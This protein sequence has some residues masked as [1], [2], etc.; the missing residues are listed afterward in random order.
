MSSCDAES[1]VSTSKPVQVVY[2][3][4][5]VGNTPSVKAWIKLATTFLNNL[6]SDERVRE[7]YRRWRERLKPLGHEHLFRACPI[8]LSPG[9]GRIRRELVASRLEWIKGNC[10]RDHAEFN[11]SIVLKDAAEL[12][13]CRDSVRRFVKTKLGLNWHGSR[14]NSPGS[15]SSEKTMRSSS[16]CPRQWRSSS[17]HLPSIPARSPFA[18]PNLD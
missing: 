11:Q 3:M 13:S 1:R 4:M 16:T 9:Y 6:D 14:T 7:L 18:R 12:C 2:T 17:F 10:D 8:A 5:V 15:W